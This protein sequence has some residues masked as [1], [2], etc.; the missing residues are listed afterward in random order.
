MGDAGHK[1]SRDAHGAG[2]WEEG[3]LSRDFL[4]KLGA[5]WG[6]RCYPLSGNEDLRRWWAEA[7]HA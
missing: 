6:C 7:V 5:E 3:S 4:D 2:P 1:S